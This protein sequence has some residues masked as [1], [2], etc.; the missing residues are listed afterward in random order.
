MAR[1][2]LLSPLEI[3]ENTA[4]SVFHETNRKFSMVKGV[5]IALRPLAPRYS[6]PDSMSELMVYNPG[7]ESEIYASPS[8]RGT[9]GL[10][11]FDDHVDGDEAVSAC[12]PYTVKL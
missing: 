7:C 4:E 10:R 8:I 1:K 6:A 11:G 5:Y 9:L 2:K 12:T 3:R